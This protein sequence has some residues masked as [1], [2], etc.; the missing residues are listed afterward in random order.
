MYDSISGRFLGRDPIG[1][2][3]GYNLTF[4]FAISGMDPSG[5]RF[6][7]GPWPQQRDL[8]D[9]FRDPEPDTEPADSPPGLDGGIFIFPNIGDFL[10]IPLVPNKYC[11][12]LRLLLSLEIKVAKVLQDPNRNCGLAQLGI[13]AANLPSFQFGYRAGCCKDFKC[14]SKFAIRTTNRYPLFKYRYQNVPATPGCVMD[15]WIYL[16]V[17][18]LL[19][20]GVCEKRKGN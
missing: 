20:L 17:D 13:M 7:V 5:K 3:N 1:Y 16:S 8:N 18:K 11:G 15:L 4:A 6:V 12:E 9:I 10:P 19:S 14:V 2:A